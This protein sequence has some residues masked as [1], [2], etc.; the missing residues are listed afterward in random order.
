MDLSWYAVRVKSRHEKAVSEILELKEFE[1]ILPLYQARNKWSDRVQTVELPLFPGYVFCKFDHQKRVPVLNT[2]GVYGIVGVG[3]QLAAIENSEIEALQKMVRSGLL[4]EPWPHLEVGESVEI[5]KGPLEGC[6]GVVVEIRK[7]FRLLLTVTLL[8]RAVHVELDRDWISKSSS[9][10]AL[11]PPIPPR[12][13]ATA[14][15]RSYARAS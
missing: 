2:P 10:R 15:V 8:Q 12:I 13:P 9:F 11:S 7:R 5:D 14:S 6:R 4:A 1:T 3:P